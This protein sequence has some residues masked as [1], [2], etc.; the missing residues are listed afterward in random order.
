MEG[1]EIYQMEL[2]NQF[3]EIKLEAPKGIYF[4]EIIAGERPYT[5]KVYL[6]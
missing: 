3:T 5:K 2:Q 1:E 6:N 4:V